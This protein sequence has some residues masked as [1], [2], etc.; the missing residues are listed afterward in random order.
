MN[1]K[2]SPA[3]EID[4]VERCRQV[5]RQIESEHPGLDAY[6]AWAMKVDKEYR[7]KKRAKSTKSKV[8]KPLSAVRK[9]KPIATR[10][11]AKTRARS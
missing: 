5:R 8:A 3:E 11:T 2:E 1:R 6:F 9:A 4:D 10:K 7:R